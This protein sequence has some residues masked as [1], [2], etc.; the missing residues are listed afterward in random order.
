MKLFKC[1]CLTIRRQPGSFRAIAFQVELDWKRC[2]KLKLTALKQLNMI[3]NILLLED[4]STFSYPTTCSLLNI[5]QA[6]LPTDLHLVGVTGHESRG[7]PH[8]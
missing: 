3:T 4:G 7:S 6:G 1:L 8:A 2:L 5:V